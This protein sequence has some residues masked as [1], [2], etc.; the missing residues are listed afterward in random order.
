MSRDGQLVV[1]I[2]GWVA[3]PRELAAAGCTCRAW[4]AASLESALWRR[5]F[6]VRTLIIIIAIA[7]TH[8]GGWRATRRR[9]RRRGSWRTRW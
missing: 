6:F 9:R 4:Y 3:G 2:L 7:Q 1:A 5:L 8:R